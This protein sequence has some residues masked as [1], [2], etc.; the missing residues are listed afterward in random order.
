MI[1]VHLRDI[2]RLLWEKVNSIPV[3]TNN[4]ISSDIDRPIIVTTISTSEV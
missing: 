3:I 1:I 2:V 4:H